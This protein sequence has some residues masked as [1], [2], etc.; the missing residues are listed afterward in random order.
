MRREALSCSTRTLIADGEFVGETAV[1]AGGT[2]HRTASRRRRDAGSATAS[3]PSAR[4]AT[5]PSYIVPEFEVRALAGETLR[6]GEAASLYL[7]DDA[8]RSRLA[9]CTRWRV[10]DARAGGVGTPPWNT[11]RRLTC[12]CG[13][14][15]GFAERPICCVAHVPC[16][17]RIAPLYRLESASGARAGPGGPTNATASG[18]A[19]H[20][21]DTQFSGA[22]RITVRSHDLYRRLG[23]ARRVHV[24]RY[25]AHARASG[26]DGRR[27]ADP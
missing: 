20:R 10:P 27:N 18:R 12:T 4:G 5:R 8:S 6:W 21:P 2:C 26:S 16:C 19:F 22:R 7:A 15:D 11:W 24:C 3:S 1:S 13:R 23:E 17:R 14:H 25:Q 9:A